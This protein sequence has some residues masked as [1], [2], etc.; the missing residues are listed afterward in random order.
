MPKPSISH[1]EET[2]DDRE[3]K[4]ESATA[5]VPVRRTRGPR[6]KNYQKLLLMQ[7]LKQKVDLP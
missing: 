5:N 2:S 7:R 4:Q 6:G 3:E 1:G